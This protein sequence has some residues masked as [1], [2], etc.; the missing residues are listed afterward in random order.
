[1]QVQ[2]ISFKGYDAR[3]LKRLVT[4]DIGQGEPFYK[5]IDEVAQIG[6]RE[7]FEVLVQTPNKIVG[8]NFSRQ[9]TGET[10]FPNKTYYPWCQ[11]TITFG[12]NNTM[13]A[14]A[15]TAEQNRTLADRAGTNYNFRMQHLQGGNFFF[16]REGSQ[17][18]LLVGREEL[19]E[20]FDVDF[21]KDFG[22]KR[23]F[24][25]SQPDYHID[26]GVRPLNDRKVLV[27]DPQLTIRKI[28]RAILNAQEYLKRHSDPQVEKVQG[29]LESLNKIFQESMK[30][31]KDYTNFDRIQKELKMFGF[32]PIRVPG[33]I[34]SPRMLTPQDNEF[35][36]MMNFIN[37]IVHERADK[38]LVYITN[39][40]LIDEAIGITPEIEEQLGFSFK[41]AFLERVKDHIAPEDVHFISADGYIAEHLQKSGGG[42]H[43]VFAEQV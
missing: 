28:E 30:I 41:K 22:V 42:I 8:D 6:K 43:C 26:L 12:P 17:N 33:S 39:D 34:I 31:F 5:L 19:K 25:I 15:I 1:M 32:K 4:R 23:I 2:D 36:Y 20:C 35:G 27:N 7:G 9:L 16:I 21:R 40:S 37:A 11:D 29:T 13:Q 14:V 18:S 10:K 24:Q 3:P 38:S